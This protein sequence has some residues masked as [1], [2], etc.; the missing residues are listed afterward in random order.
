MCGIRGG[1]KRTIDKAVETGVIKKVSKN[2]VAKNSTSVVKKTTEK[3][4]KVLKEEAP[5]SKVVKN[6]KVRSSL[7]IPTQNLTY[8]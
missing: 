8:G 2:P 3:K 1:F 7:R 6:N 5:V 4:A